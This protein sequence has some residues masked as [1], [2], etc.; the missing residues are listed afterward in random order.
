MT[1]L[2]ELIEALQA[3]RKESG[4]D[5]PVRVTVPLLSEGPSEGPRVRKVWPDVKFT[6]HH[7][8]LHVHVEEGVADE[9][10]NDNMVLLRCEAEWCAQEQML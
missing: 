4:K 10:D 9:V 7:A 1:T 5:I 2:D 3:A 6:Y 8:I